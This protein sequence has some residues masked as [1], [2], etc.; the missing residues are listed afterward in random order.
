MTGRYYRMA[1]GKTAVESG[2]SAPATIEKEP[3]ALVE[4]A[5]QLPRGEQRPEAQRAAPRS[6]HHHQDEL[7]GR[8]AG[9]DRPQF[10]AGD[11]RFQNPRDAL[12]PSRRAE[13]V[14]DAR[15]PGKPR[16]L[17]NDDAVQRKRLRGQRD[18]E[19]MF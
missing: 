11:P 6:A 17:G 1:K 18:L 9:I 19:H 16:C 13:L 12:D 8:E 2:A 7:L 15:E 5:A 3:N 4:P 14:K 10:A